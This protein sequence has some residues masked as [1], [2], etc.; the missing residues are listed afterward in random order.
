LTTSTLDRETRIGVVVTTLALGA[1]AVDHLLEEDGGFAA[2]PPAFA[3]A[4]VLSL[5]LALL[6]FGVV[7]PRVLARPD[8]ADRA[9]T[10]GLVSS[11][12][13]VASIPVLFLGPPFVLGGSGVALGLLGRSGRK[14]GRATAAVVAGSTVVVL[15]AVA[16]TA[17]AIDKLV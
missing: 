17:V 3:I 13:A 16:Y 12:L 9:A 15:G 1:M 11:V 7:V 14:H 8:S 4:G 6:L 2:D 10:I 5:L